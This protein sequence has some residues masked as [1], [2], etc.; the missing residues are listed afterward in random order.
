LLSGD[1]PFLVKAG[2]GR[3]DF[4]IT[5]EPARRRAVEYGT[6]ARLISLIDEAVGADAHEESRNSTAQRDNVQMPSSSLS[7]WKKKQRI[8]EE[9]AAY[10]F[11]EYCFQ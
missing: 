5:F 9:T 2:L 3:L 7:S 1:E 8:G 11:K 4:L 10:V 6:I